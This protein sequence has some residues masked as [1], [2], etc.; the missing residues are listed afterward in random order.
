VRAGLTAAVTLWREH[1]ALVTAMFDAAA[2][3]PEVAA[4]W[5]TFLTSLK[6][7][8]RDRIERDRRLGLAPTT[9]PAADLAAVLIDMTAY[10]MERDVRDGP[11][12]H[13]VE[14]LVHVWDRALY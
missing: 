7:R 5:E 14:S 1:A 13:T 6:D 3:D 12:A 4:I 11:L 8:G 2:S 9:I 10:A